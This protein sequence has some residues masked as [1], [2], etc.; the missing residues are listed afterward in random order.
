MRR[1]AGGTVARW[2]MD[3]ESLCDGIRMIEG[4]VMMYMLNLVLVDEED[5]RWDGGW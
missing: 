3:G 5:R 1:T 2:D 4:C